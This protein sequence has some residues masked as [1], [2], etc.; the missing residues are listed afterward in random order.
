M[1]Q[2]IKRVFISL[3]FQVLFNKIQKEEITPKKDYKASKS[4]ER[5]DSSFGIFLNLSN[6]LFF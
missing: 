6:F 3:H 4:S 5:I 1:N 2:L